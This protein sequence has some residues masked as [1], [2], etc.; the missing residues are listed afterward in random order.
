MF[1]IASAL[2]C[3]MCVTTIF[4]TSRQRTRQEKSTPV[5][6]IIMD[7]GRDFAKA[8]VFWTIGITCMT[9]YLIV[10][11]FVATHSLDVVIIGMTSLV[12]HLSVLIL[13]ANILVR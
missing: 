6:W 2:T 9:T 7:V 4:I 12:Y 13:H 5:I 3:L 1:T 11:L 10:Y 8:W